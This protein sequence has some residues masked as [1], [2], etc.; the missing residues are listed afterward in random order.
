MC[1]RYVNDSEQKMLLIANMGYIY[2]H[3]PHDYIK[4]GNVKNEL[5]ALIDMSIAREFTI[6]DYRIC[7]NIWIFSSVYELR[8]ENALRL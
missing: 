1:R 3:E 8:L 2:K 6:S 5:V 4:M 7:F